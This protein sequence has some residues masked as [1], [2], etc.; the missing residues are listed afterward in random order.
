[1]LTTQL[2]AQSPCCAEQF[3]LNQDGSP[4]SL[5]ALQALGGP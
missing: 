1:M 4:E 3:L 2:W 5:T